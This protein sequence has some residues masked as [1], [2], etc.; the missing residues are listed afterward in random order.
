MNL[1]ILNLVATKG[2]T[3]LNKPA[4]KNNWCDQV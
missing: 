1:F 4:A 3:Y 2:Y